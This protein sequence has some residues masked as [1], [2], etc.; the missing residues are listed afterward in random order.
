MRNLRMLSPLLRRLM[1]GLEVKP[2]LAELRERIV[3]ECDYELE[4]ANHR[5]VA[6][7]W[8]GHPFVAVPAV[9]TALSRRRV[10][11]T[12]WVDGIGFDEVAGSRT[13]SATAT[14]RSSTASSTAPPASSTW[15][16]ATRTRA[17]TCSATT[18]GSR[19]S[20][21]ACCATCRAA[22]WTARRVILAAIR[23]GDE[24][25]LLEAM[26]ELGYLP[27]MPATGTASLLLDYM[28]AV[29]LVAAR[30]RAAAACAR[31]P[32]ARQRVAA[33]RP[34]RASS[35]QQMRR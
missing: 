17:T 20:T 26:R 30:R 34:Q 28:R 6:R 23:D 15:R 3:E 11:V 21:S 19:S 5:R 18:A 25:A 16:S 35:A 29:S 22:T 33:R 12:E 14:R 8:R 9:D 31:G 10:L 7:F 24:P 2:V 13:R 4:A 27:G 1:P 32:L